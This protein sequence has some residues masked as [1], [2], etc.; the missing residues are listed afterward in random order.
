MDNYSSKLKHL[1]CKYRSTIADTHLEN[2]LRLSTAQFEQEDRVAI[3][4]YVALIQICYSFI[5]IVFLNFF[6]IYKLLIK[7]INVVIKVSKKRKNK[8]P[9]C[10]D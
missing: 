1:K 6:V 3:K 9:K 5:F 10:V 4:I 7:G 8:S 2:N